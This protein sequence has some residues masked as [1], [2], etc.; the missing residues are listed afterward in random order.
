MMTMKRALLAVVAVSAAAVAPA[1]AQAPAQTGS[2]SFPP[3]PEP[4]K[5]YARCWIPDQYETLTEQVESKPETK[6]LETIPAV[7]ETV[8]EQVLVKEASKRLEVIPAVYETVTEQVTVK[9]AGK[10]LESVPPVYETVSEEIEVASAS[11]RWVRGKADATCVSTNPDD[12]QVWCLETVP[13]QKRTVTKTVLKTPATAREVEIP[14]EHST[15]TKTV[16]R[17]PPTTREVEIPAEYRTITKT[18]MKTPPTTREL[19]TPA[20]YQTV[21]KR[22]LVKAGGYLDWREAVCGKDLTTARII[23]IQRAL[24]TAGYDTGPIDNVL[25]PRTRAALEKFQRDKGLPVGGLNLE[26]LKALGVE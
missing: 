14:A 26:T 4:G 8:T 2:D 15:I 16:L 21:S 13:A 17:T 9:E 11:T 19:V 12:C 25:G 24:Q 6:R 22:Q 20:V 7:F 10:R 1:W 18:V 5:C 23:A 3:N